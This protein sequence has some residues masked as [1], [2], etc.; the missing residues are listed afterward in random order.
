MPSIWR[1]LFPL[2]KSITC[3][4]TY[5]HGKR[6]SYSVVHKAVQNSASEYTAK[7]PALKNQ[8]CRITFHDG[9]FTNNIYRQVRIPLSPQ[10]QVL[11]WIAQSTSSDQQWRIFK[12]FFEFQQ[13]YLYLC[14]P[15]RKNGAAWWDGWVAET[16]SLLNW[17]TG[18]RTGGSNPPLT[19]EGKAGWH[20]SSGFC[21]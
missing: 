18:N 11:I 6:E 5:T 16:T 7:S 1:Y 17:R 14:S 2:G 3:T 19:A 12:R 10:Q 15:D 8:C 13:I 9:E 4:G 21:V 20:L